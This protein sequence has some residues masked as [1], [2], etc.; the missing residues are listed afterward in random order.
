[1]IQA[2]QL[3]MGLNPPL[4]IMIGGELFPAARAIRYEVVPRCLWCGNGMENC[5]PARSTLGTATLD[6]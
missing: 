6:D 1:M 3:E 4:P 2:G 5:E